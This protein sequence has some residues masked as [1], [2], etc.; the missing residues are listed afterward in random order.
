[1]PHSANFLAQLV[2]GDF[3]TFQVLRTTTADVINETTMTVVKMETGLQ[4]AQGIAGPQG[5]QGEQGLPGDPGPSTTSDS[6]II[7]SDDNG[8]P[9]ILSFG[10]ALNKTL[11]F[12]RTND[13]FVLTDRL[14]IGL[15]GTLDGLKITTTA[16]ATDN[17]QNQIE[18][19]NNA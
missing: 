9:Q 11:Y 18:V 4:G 6:Y 3:I 7:D 10:S 5:A 13:Y 2:A 17:D 8:N 19:R 12:D 14:N 15:S 1:M 16:S